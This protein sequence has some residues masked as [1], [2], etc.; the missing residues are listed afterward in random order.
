MKDTQY[1][2]S[3][4]I[5]TWNSQQE[6]SNCLVSVRASTRN[7]KTEIIVVDNNSTDLTVRTIRS[8]FSTVHILQQKNNLGFGQGNNIG[9]LKAKGRY[10]LLLN[11][12]TVVNPYAMHQMIYFLDTHPR[13]GFVGPEQFNDTDRMIFM[14]S[15]LSPVGFTEYVIEKIF[16]FV[17]GKTSV[18]FPKPHKTYMLNAGCL[19]TRN[20]IL[21]TRQ[22]F[23]PDCFI[24]GEENYLF[25]R[26]HE[27]NWEVYF[28]RNCSIIH[29]REKSIM[30]TNSKMRFAKD[31][32][33]VY[34]KKSS[35]GKLLFSS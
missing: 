34:L 6:I 30:Q 32:A 3:V 31:S 14:A 21:S 12:D 25:K 19:L 1:Q 24:Y 5:F 18:L 22:W 4:I 8:A 27:Q 2:L 23:D 15:R 7:I 28:L 13:V 17:T 29:L 20:N 9:L 33:K 35:V 10:I 26:V 11:P 16:H